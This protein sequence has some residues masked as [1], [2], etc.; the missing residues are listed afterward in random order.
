[1]DGWMGYNIEFSFQK[2]N[3]IKNRGPASSSASWMH[4]ICRSSGDIHRNNGRC[5][6]QWRNYTVYP[7]WPGNN[8]GFLIEELE[9]SH[10]RDVRNILLSLLDVGKFRI[11]LKLLAFKEG[12][13]LLWATASKD[14]ACI[15]IYGHCVCKG[16]TVEH[17]RY[18]GDK[19]D[20]TLNIDKDDKGQSKGLKYYC[21]TCSDRPLFHHR[22][23]ESLFHS[24]NYGL[25]LLQWWFFSEKNLCTFQRFRNYGMGLQS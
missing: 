3:L 18:D 25:D 15:F 7:I 22:N 1:M 23:F 13:I 5:L 4:H 21:S 16:V 24:K 2:Q 6:I 11:L 12:L 19:G 17:R 9:N 20:N 14:T 8:K 10:R